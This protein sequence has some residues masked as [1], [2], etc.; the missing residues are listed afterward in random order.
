MAAA[1][2]IG[3][4][5]AG[6]V[7]ER[8]VAAYHANPSPRRRDHRPRAGSG[9]GA[10]PGVRRGLRGVL[11]GSAREWRPRRRPRLRAARP[12]FPRRETATAAGVHILM[13][14]PIANTPEEAD[15]VIERVERSGKQLMIGFVHRFRTEVQEARRLLSEGAIGTPSTA[16]DRFCSLGGPH[17]PAWVWQRQH[18]GGGVLMYGGIHAIDRLLWWLGT[19][20]TSVSARWHHTYGDGDTPFARSSIATRP[21]SRRLR[22]EPFDEMHFSARLTSSYRPCSKAASYRCRRQLGVIRS[23]S[24]W[25]STGRLPRARA[26]IWALRR[27]GARALQALSARALDGSNTKWLGYCSQLTIKEP[28]MVAKHAGPARSEVRYPSGHWI[29]AGARR[30]RSSSS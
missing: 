13:E 7:A 12:A 11:R 2:A 24:P 9:A 18:A 16:V 21:S 26:A 3:V 19:R 25:R 4:I 14:K 22:A 23:R 15:S 5:G 10:R 28:Q 6:Q 8:D 17:P 1:L 20:V 30:A 27:E 29:R